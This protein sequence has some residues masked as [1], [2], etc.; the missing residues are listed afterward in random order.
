MVTARY[1]AV[2]C[3]QLIRIRYYSLSYL[4]GVN[5]QSRQPN[6]R[7]SVLPNWQYRSVNP[8]YLCWVGVKPGFGHISVEIAGKFTP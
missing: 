3:Q 2:V 6:W 1:L 7:S 8:R 4:S 5:L